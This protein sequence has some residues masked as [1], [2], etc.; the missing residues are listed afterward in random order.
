[1]STRRIRKRKTTSPRGKG[2]YTIYFISLPE[3]VAD[4]VPNDMR[5]KV[6]L[7]EDGILLKPIV[8]QPTPP[9]PSW[10]K[11]PLP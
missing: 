9:L 8:P 7:T 4:K 10:C 3:E 2:E 11:K 1:M 5:F 6:E